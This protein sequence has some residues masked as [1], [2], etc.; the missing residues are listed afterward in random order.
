[1]IQKYEIRLSWPKIRVGMRAGRQKAMQRAEFTA[2]GP[3][4]TQKAL[5]KS[6]M[7]SWIT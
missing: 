1:L 4:A 5:V 6:S 3:T 7:G 2:R